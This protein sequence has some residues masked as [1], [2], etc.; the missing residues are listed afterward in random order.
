MINKLF[1]FLIL[2][3]SF[4]FAEQYKVSL[5]LLPL[6]AESL[7]KGTTVDLSKLLAEVTGN[8]IEIS[9]APFPRSIN[10]AIS[11]ESDFHIPLIK[12]PYVDQNKLSFNYS[13][14]E[15]YTVNFV[16]YTRKD[17]YI[18]INHLEKYAIYTDRAHVDYFNFK[19]NPIT[20]SKSALEMIDLGRIDGYIFADVEV[21][22]I[23]KKLNLKS[24]K[25]QLYK[26]YGVHAVLPKNEKSVQID[27]MISKGMKII[28]E[29]GQWNI[30]LG[31]YYT[32]YVDWQ[33]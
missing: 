17:K 29:N 3:T 12:N 15:L 26:T 30:I 11:G 28:R 32:N 31:K 13:T 2:S 7:E 19:I 24:I 8:K 10:S 16:L 1:L 14:A 18:D 21:D 27:T 9:L 6:S 4:C 23:L 33:P 25:R 20:H 22:P 5:A